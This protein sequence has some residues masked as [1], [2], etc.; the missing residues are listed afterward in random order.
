[1][2][3][4]GHWGTVYDDGWDMKDVAVGAGIWA[5]GQPSTHLQAPC[6]CQ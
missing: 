1:M 4:E 3:E 2:D 5:V 6:I